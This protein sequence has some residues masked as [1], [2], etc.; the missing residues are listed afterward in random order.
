MSSPIVL[1]PNWLHPCCLECCPVS[2]PCNILSNQSEAADQ[3]SSSISVYLVLE[4]N[5][6]IN[7]METKWSPKSTRMLV[8]AESS[9]PHFQVRG[10]RVRV[11]RFCLRLLPMDNKRSQSAFRPQRSNV[12]CTQNRCENSG[13]RKGK[14]WNKFA[15]YMFHT[16]SIHVP[17]MFHIFPYISMFHLWNPFAPLKL[18]KTKLC[19]PTRGPDSVERTIFW[20]P[21]GFGHQRSQNQNT[22]VYW[23]MGY[24]LQNYSSNG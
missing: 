10:T 8:F 23:R 9:L 22:R 1:M 4:L 2:T 20:P 16:C 6:L 24:A 13:I 18:W 21:D 3:Q 11:L 15:I 5:W 14:R 7:C 19:C 12:S 17:Y